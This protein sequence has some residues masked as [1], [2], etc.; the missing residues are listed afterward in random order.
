MSFGYAHTAIYQEVYLYGI[1]SSDT[2]GAQTMDAF[3]VRRGVDDFCY[4]SFYRGAKTYFGQLVKGR[5]KD[6]PS[7][8]YD[9]EAHDA[10]R[11]WLEKK[12]MI[13]EED[14]SRDTEKDGE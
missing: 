12:P 9:E 3:D 5:A 13:P 6:A 7:H 1:E 8:F 14:R 4:F 2:A 10:C 11:Q